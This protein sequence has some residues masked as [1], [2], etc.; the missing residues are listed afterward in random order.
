MKSSKLVNSVSLESDEVKTVEIASEVTRDVHRWAPWLRLGQSLQYCLILQ[1]TVGRTRPMSTKKTFKTP[2]VRRLYRTSQVDIGQRRVWQLGSNFG[3]PEERSQWEGTGEEAD[4]DKVQ[5][6]FFWDLL[7]LL[8]Q[9]RLSIVI[10]WLFIFCHT[11][12]LLP[13]I[14]ETIQMEQGDLTE[15]ERVASWPT[16]LVVMEHLSHFFI[17]LNSAINFLIYLFL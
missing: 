5:K 16:W 3:Q 6:R 2:I 11:W 14:Y 12:K 10:V 7:S 17:T 4:Q 9:P 15:R 1:I 13:T 8:T